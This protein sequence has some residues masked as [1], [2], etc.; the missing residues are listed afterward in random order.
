[1]ADV[2]AATGHASDAR[3][4]VAL[5]ALVNGILPGAYFNSSG[6]VWDTG[7]QTA[8]VVGLQFA[9]G[10]E[11]TTNN[12]ASILAALVDGI[13]ADGITVGMSG[14]RWL[15]QA[16]TSAGRGDLALQLALRTAPPSWGAMALGTASQ[17][18]L[19]TFWESWAGPDGKGSSGNHIFL[20]GGLG[21]WLYASGLGLS[22]RMLR[23][24]PSGGGGEGSEGA[25][26]ARHLGLAAD[27][28]ATH[29][30]EA[31]EVCAVAA[32]VAAARKDAHTRGAK[33]AYALSSL[34]RRS[35]AQRLDG[36]ASERRASAELLPVG[37]LRLDAHLVRGLRAASGHVRTPQGDLA[38]SWAL[39]ED[40]ALRINA[41]VPH[42]TAFSIFVPSE[43]LRASSDD[44]PRSIAC[45]F[46]APTSAAPVI[47]WATRSEAFERIPT[48]GEAGRAYLRVDLASSETWT[49]VF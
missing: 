13:A 34:R 39:G 47:R 9:L 27:L 12:S 48:A 22:F 32:L 31:A 11:V 38:A 28:R 30:M 29:G 10:G 16:L 18:P 41:S 2:A 40:D 44:A 17:P 20:A 26:C 33:A 49:I 42:A 6:R 45:T 1:M 14:T 46:C 8:Q 37:R 7:S 15:L 5:A 36:D 3:A 4:F 43:L 24:S 19:G 25:S 23:P 21:E 35:A